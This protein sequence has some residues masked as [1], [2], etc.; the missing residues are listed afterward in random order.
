MELSTFGALLTFAIELEE[1]AA[2]FYLE[3]AEGVEHAGAKETFS[4]FARQNRSRK[5]LL[6]A[7]RQEHVTE[8]VLEPITDLH[9][10]DYEIEP[11]STRGSTES[12]RSGMTYTQVLAQAREMESRAQRF[13][14]DAAGK[15]RHL[16][17]GVAR[18]FARLAREKEK[19]LQELEDL[20]EEASTG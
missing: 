18:S 8:M 12:P 16:L 19:R 3:A 1:R 6:V 20:I 10:S 17:A 11:K 15:A 5:A 13:Y 7:T 9:R 14:A 4:A 2:R